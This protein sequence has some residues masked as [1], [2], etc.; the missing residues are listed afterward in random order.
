M[1]SCRGSNCGPGSRA[2]T[3]HSPEIYT[4]VCTLG[5]K[6]VTGKAEAELTSCQDESVLPSLQN[7]AQD[8]ASV[9]LQQHSSTFW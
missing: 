8:T 4:K 6:S 2:G 5:D 9:S 3:L 7:P 1:V